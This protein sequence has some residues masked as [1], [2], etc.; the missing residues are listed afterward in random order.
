MTGVSLG[1]F[2]QS[3]MLQ[4]RGVSLRAELTK[5]S[6]EMSTGQVSDVRE[7]L[8]GNV[9]FL[10]DMERDLRI[11][12]AYR[13]AGLE[14]ESYAN[15]AQLSLEAFQTTAGDLATSIVAGSVTQTSTTI[16][17]NA[18]EARNSLESMMAK[19]NGDI[20]GRSLFSGVATKTV[21]LEDASTLL[22]TLEFLI[23]G[24]ATPADARLAAETWF[25]DP[26]GFSATI[27]QGSTDDL[28]P[29]RVGDGEDVAIN[30]RADNEAFRDAL[31]NVA[32]AS[33]ASS[34]ALSFNSSQRAELQR[35]SGIALQ[36]NQEDLTNVR[37]RIGTAEAR[38][39]AIE[40][41][42]AAEKTSLEIARNDLLGVDPFETATK[43]ED[44]QFR[45]QSIYAVTARLS[46][47]S[48]VNFIQ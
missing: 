31:M 15:T 44:V 6:E 47:L 13:I 29:F 34:S 26:S 28:S 2:A 33:L 48:L 4:R 36:S 43:L 18:F 35:D 11:L 32:L 22:N 41:R 17:Q 39:D 42:N 14:A 1:D 20:G 5:L 30:I 7:V 19:L 16:E 3:F 21:P 45:L 12:D 25:D 27:Y 37:A 23:A 46:D 40:T 8:A 24:A 38:L 9:S 10:A